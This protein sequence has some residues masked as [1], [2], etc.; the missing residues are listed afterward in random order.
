[1]TIS[2]TPFTVDG[3]L[4]VVEARLTGPAGSRAYQ[5]L[6]DTGATVTTIT[7]ELAEELGYSASD[8]RCHTRVTSAVATESGYILDVA[9][10]SA[11]GITVTKFPVQVFDLAP[12]ALD[13]LLGMNFLSELDF[14]ILSS[15][16]VI[17]VG[18]DKLEL[19]RLRD[20]HARTSRALDEALVSAK[21]QRER[22]EALEA[23]A[24]ML[25][26]RLDAARR[27]VSFRLGR[28]A[29][30]PRRWREILQGHDEILDDAGEPP[31]QAEPVF[32]PGLPG[33]PTSSP[34]ATLDTLTP[35]G[36]RDTLER[37]P[38]TL[39]LIRA[40]SLASGTPWGDWGTPG[41]RD[42]LALVGE[43]VAWCR[44][45]RIP[46]AFVGAPVPRLAFD[47]IL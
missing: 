23:R 5:L 19:A 20:A 27:S 42:G 13:G 33:P 45:R 35:H 2:V 26:R 37:D 6:L 43:L 44:A 46:V 36:W 38:P 16:Q 39:V 4:I 1:M 31:S 41:G 10:L 8:G 9:E 40:E 11:L 25:L 18:A 28:A 32:D 34:L 24:T 29:R 22:A 12:E 15:Q 21:H 14:E 7:H 47:L 17:R 30:D 3:D